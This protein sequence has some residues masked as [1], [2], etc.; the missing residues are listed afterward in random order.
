MTI[1]E[2][3]RLKS[4][5]FGF[6]RCGFA[7]VVPLG[8]ECEILKKYLENGYQG[9]MQYLE[10]HFE[11]RTDPA[12]LVPNA[13]TVISL[14]VN[15]YPSQKQHPEFPQIAKYAYGRDYHKV[16]KK[17]LKNFY[18]WL[19]ETFACEGRYFVDS[20]PVLERAWAMR[21]GL[22]W[23][24]KNG[25]L[26]NRELGSFCFIAELIIDLPLDYDKPEF[27]RCGTCRRCLDDCPTQALVAPHVL[28]GSKC[29]S[30]YTIENKA[31]HIDPQPNLSNRIFGCDICQDVCPWNKKC[32]PHDVAD[33]MPKA[34]RLTIDRTAWQQMDEQQYQ[35]LFFGS[36]V[37]RASFQM[38]KRNFEKLQ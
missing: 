7:E 3:I 27:N 29:I 13:K 12:L 19:N 26:I 35:D 9:N 2:Q 24:G 38:L 15:Y 32:K 37:K 6:D 1:T 31:E 30:Y 28:D 11:K 21:A 4:A 18:A 17:N 36:A 10:N 25:C 33:F 34:E 23:I 22:G 5:D 8:N 16:I 14:L 20:A